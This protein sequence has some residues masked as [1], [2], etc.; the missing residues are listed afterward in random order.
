MRAALSVFMLMVS[1][2]VVSAQPGATSLV[3]TVTLS[4]TKQSSLSVNVVSGATQTLATFADNAITQFP[5]P[6]RIT[7]AW[8]VG[9][10]TNS[11][12][13]VAYFASAT[14]A[15]ANG[16]NYLASSRVQG[17]VLTTPTTTWQPTN[18]RAFTQNGNAG[19][20]VN[21]A[22]LRLMLQ[23]INA[24]NRQSSRTMDLDL[25]MNLVG[26]PVTTAGTYSGTIT[27]RAFTT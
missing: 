8:S 13:L 11:V 26:Q 5:T 17:R 12:R 15:L 25:R 7:A 24:S 19:V 21:G 6:V 4:A 18:W 10:S 3:R 14:Q 23:T 27:L 16:T 2:A 22:T 1:S 9:P 20:G